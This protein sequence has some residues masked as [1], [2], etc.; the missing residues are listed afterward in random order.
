MNKNARIELQYI[1]L[2]LQNFRTNHLRHFIDQYYCYKKGY[3]TRGGN[4][5]WELIVWGENEAISLEASKTKNR[6]EVVKEHVIPLK[7]VTQELMKLPVAE[8]DDLNVVKNCINKFLIYGTITKEEDARLRKLKLTSTMPSEY[9]DHHH[10][11]FNDPYARYHGADIKLV[12]YQKN[13]SGH[14]RN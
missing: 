13:E 11:W 12:Q 8:L 6:K 3:V 10:D 5:K 14:D 4:P 1:Q 2:E 7:R 9:D